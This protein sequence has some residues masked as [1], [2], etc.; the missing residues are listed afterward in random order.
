MTIR[1]RYPEGNSRRSGSGHAK[2]A[3]LERDG[4]QE[5][6]RRHRADDGARPDAALVLHELETAQVFFR[7]GV[8]RATEEGSQTLHMPNIIL[9]GVGTETPHHH[10]ML[11]PLTQRADRG[12]V[13]RDSH[14]KFLFAEGNSNLRGQPRPAKG[15]Y[16][17]HYAAPSDPPAERVRAWVEET[18]ELI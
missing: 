15:P 10:V 11:H 17:P 14:G 9:L 13:D 5:A 7:R 18:Y 6:E 16:F 4:E 12:G 1:L 3:P 8:G 2:F